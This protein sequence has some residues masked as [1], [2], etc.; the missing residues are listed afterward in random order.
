MADTENTVEPVPWGD[1]EATR[2]TL[3]KNF[4]TLH[5]QARKGERTLGEIREQAERAARDLTAMDQR[6]AQMAA[7]SSANAPSDG[8]AAELRSFKRSAEAGGRPEHVQLFRS[9]VTFRGTKIGPQ[10]GLLDADPIY[11]DWHRDVK[12][13]Y[14]ALQ[15]TVAAKR[16][17]SEN[18]NDPHVW[19]RH[20]PRSFAR[21]CFALERAP[22]GLAAPLKR[23]VEHLWSCSEQVNRIFND[24]NGTGGEFIPDEV[25]LPELEKD[26]KYSDFPL[27]CDNIATTPTS[28]VNLRLP[29]AGTGL[30]PYLYGYASS[31]TPPAFTASTP[32]T[33]ERQI[34]IKGF[35]VR[36]PMDRDAVED[37]IIDALPEM[38]AMIA[39]ALKLGKED[40]F[41][42]GDTAASHQDALA[43]WN[44]NSLWASSGMGGTGDHRRAFLGMRARALDIGSGA[45]LDLSGAVTYAKLNQLAGLLDP[46]HG[47]EG[48][49]MLMTSYQDYFAH[50][51]GI[52]EVSTVE[53]YGQG[54]TVLTG[55]VARIGPW[56]IVR[57][58][59]L[60]E[61]LNASGVFDNATTTKSSLVGI[62]RRRYR[63]Y[64]RMGVMVE[65]DTEIINNVVNLVAR[66]RIGLHSADHGTTVDSSSVKNIAYGYNL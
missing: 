22:A 38:R 3:D 43:N 36:L 56:S 7:T 18:R 63:F 10:N 23:Q 2:R 48:D 29:F 33:S 8:P 66:L 39:R 15:I 27:A 32:S 55:E 62:N 31:D 41:I 5:E 28:T 19:R 25:R 44:P 49:L 52:S 21:L 65:M 46:P 53:K 50:L 14:E 35:A 51:L 17:A 13:Q 60:T 58:P 37:S 59:V 9:D 47:V 61:D 34:A 1:T 42:N 64:E 20:A 24:T 26:L 54:A 40:A 57:S 30:L 16:G 6:L 4:R 12:R 45:Q 11:G